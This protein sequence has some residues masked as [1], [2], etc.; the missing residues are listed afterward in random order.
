MSWH[1]PNRPTIPMG[2]L[3]PYELPNQ[4]MNYIT[5]LTQHPQSIHYSL[6]GSKKI[7]KQNGDQ[8]ETQ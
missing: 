2:P 3:L 8:C 4:R 1:G 6:G 7:D 5:S